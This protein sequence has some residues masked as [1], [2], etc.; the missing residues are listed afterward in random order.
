MEGI[1]VISEDLLKLSKEA[2]VVSCFQKRL[3][4]I[5]S[6]IVTKQGKEASGLMKYVVDKYLTPQKK[7]VHESLS[8][9]GLA[10]FVAK[11]VS[12]VFE[13]K[14]YKM[15]VPHVL[16]VGYYT[17]SSRWNSDLEKE[18][19]VTSGLG[20]G[21]K[22]FV[23]ESVRSGGIRLTGEIDSELSSLLGEYRKLLKIEEEE[24]IVRD[25]VA[26]P[27]VWLA[28]AKG[29]NGDVSQV[30]DAQKEY[31]R[32][33]MGQFDERGYPKQGKK[34]VEV[35][36]KAR[37]VWVPEN[38]TVE[39]NYHIPDLKQFE[40]SP[41][42]DRFH[43]LVREVLGVQVGRDSQMTQFTIERDRQ[44]LIESLQSVSHDLAQAFQ[45]MFKQVN[46]KED[47]VEFSVP[48]RIM[49]DRESVTFL[50][51]RGV[52]PKEDSHTLLLETHGIQPSKKVR[53]E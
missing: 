19:T 38:H 12:F 43:N 7:V 18:Y 40:S 51:D 34:E 5:M 22:Y 21:L 27:Y 36:H 3:S 20:D 24:A 13:G 10:V 50:E 32:L 29:G 35:D 23:V 1:S 28:N 4:N 11:S 14:I 30:A 39:K 47:G 9:L 8:I 2:I 53:L 45:K 15:N 42:R 31:E 44:T 16:D 17:I 41:S 49:L 52:I 26:R 46:P 48:Q 37:I 6:L 25:L 33:L